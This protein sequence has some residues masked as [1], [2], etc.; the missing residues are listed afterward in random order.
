MTTA[1]T[2]TPGPWAFESMTDGEVNRIQL[3][4]VGTGDRTGNK[5][6]LGF[7][8]PEFLNDKTNLNM[9]E[10]NA[11]LIASAPE[12]AKELERVKALN[13]QM[14]EALKPFAHEDLCKT[15]S[16][17]IQG[18]ESIIYQRDTAILKLGDFR[19]ARVAIK[20]AEGN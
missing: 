4:A 5:R 13:A 7:L 12:T 8:R 19:K 17:N 3:L 1:N 18:D 2:H 16:G 15:L 11:R 14:L 9:Q 20:S 6:S 10:A